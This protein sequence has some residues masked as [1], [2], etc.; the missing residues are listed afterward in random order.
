MSDYRNLDFDPLTPGDPSRRNGEMDPDLRAA[1]VVWGWLVAAIFVVVV[2]A[3]AFG[4]ARQPGQIGTNTASNDIT[5]PPAATH[6]APPAA[7]QASKPATTMAPPMGPA[8]NG[9][10]A[11]PGQPN[12]GQ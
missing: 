9:A 4:I 8:P 1:N 2:L 3:V 5:A 6:M 12:G 7:Q 11:T 10:P